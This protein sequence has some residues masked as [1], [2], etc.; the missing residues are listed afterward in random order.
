MSLL[1]TYIMYKNYACDPNV[2]L[3]FRTRLPGFSY[4]IINRKYEKGSRTQEVTA[5]EEA[6]DDD[7]Y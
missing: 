4:D 3:C 1:T 2:L 7:K 6:E 5:A